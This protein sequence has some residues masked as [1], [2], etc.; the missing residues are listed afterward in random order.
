MRKLLKGVPRG[1]GTGDQRN[2]L[3]PAG[4]RVGGAHVKPGD[5]RSQGKDDLSQEVLGSESDAGLRDR[6]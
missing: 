1:G 4:I 5:Q 2:L 3:E 6:L